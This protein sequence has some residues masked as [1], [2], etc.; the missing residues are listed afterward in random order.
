MVCRSKSGQIKV[1]EMIF[2]LLFLFIFFSIIFLFYLRFS[3]NSVKKDFYVSS[4]EGSIQLVS[5]IAD[6]PELSCGY[7]KTLCVDADKLIVLTNHNNYKSYW[8]INGLVVTRI[9]PYQNQTI[10]CNLANY[11]NCN[12]YVI[13]APAGNYVSDSSYVILCHREYENPYNYDKCDLAK[14]TVYTAKKD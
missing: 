14:I 11:P 4:R 8:D 7:S 9:Y 12:T 6:S 10:E 3:L 2:M 5:R 13:K 1:Q